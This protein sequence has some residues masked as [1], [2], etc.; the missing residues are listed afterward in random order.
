MSEEDKGI[1]KEFIEMVGKSSTKKLEEELVKSVDD[2]K[3]VDG[4]KEFHDRLDEVKRVVQEGHKWIFSRIELYVR[5]VV[6]E[7]IYKKSVERSKMEVMLYNF[8]DEDVP[9][10]VGKL[11]KNGMN[12]VPS[13][14]MTKQEIDIRV[15]NALLEY[16]NRLARRRKILDIAVYIPL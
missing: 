11:L 16:V 4:L 9:E 5:S 10:N 8:V 14:R 15:E 6:K 12:S 1:M 13:T 2:L 3:V 7:T